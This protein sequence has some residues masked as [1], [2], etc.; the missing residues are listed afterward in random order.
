[1]HLP[2]RSILFGH[3]LSLQVFFLGGIPYALLLM[4]LT[5][6]ASPVN[7]LVDLRKHVKTFGVCAYRS[8]FFWDLSLPCR[9]L[10]FRPYL[11]SHV[12]VCLR[13]CLVCQFS[14]VYLCI[15]VNFLSSIYALQVDVFGLSCLPF[16]FVL[17]PSM[18][19]AG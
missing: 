7:F 15:A 1:M 17:D 6:F 14:F 2:D 3:S 9:S 19:F 8:G 11:S 13:V 12:N 18:P 16:I 4:F 10:F 5:L